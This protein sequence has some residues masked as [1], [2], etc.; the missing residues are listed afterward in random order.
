LNH[1]KLLWDEPPFVFQPTLAR[2]LGL[3]ES[4][5]LQQIHYWLHRGY[6][7]EHDGE[8]WIYNSISQWEA[9]VSFLSRKQIRYAL[10]RLEDRGMVVTGQYNQKKF[11]RTKWYRI[12][13]SA[14][15]D[16]EASAFAT[17]GKPSARDGKPSATEGKPSALQGEPIP[18]TTP[19]IT[20]ETTSEDVYTPSAVEGV[21]NPDRDEPIPEW[22]NRLRTLPLWSRRGAKQEI[23]LIQWIAGKGYSDE[24]LEASAIGVANMNAETLAKKSDLSVVFQDRLMKGYDQPKGHASRG[25][26]DKKPSLY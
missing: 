23:E 8:M 5:M 13:Y 11:D 2:L 7:K 16:I 21:E 15:R 12:D 14:V 6:G 9:Q 20:S 10:E 17:E 18:E 3:N 22:L 26:F 1:S 25:L 24:H 19:E 4:I